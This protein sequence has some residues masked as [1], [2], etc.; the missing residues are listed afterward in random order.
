M[1]KSSNTIDGL[2]EL[3]TQ[4]GTLNKQIEKLVSEKLHLK[5]IELFD[6][7]PNLV[8]FSWTQYANFF[9]DGDPCNFYVHTDSESIDVEF[10]EDEGDSKQLDDRD[11][12]KSYDYTT[13]S[14]KDTGEADIN[15]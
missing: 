13:R 7:Y 10:A 8:S 14:Y 5:F 15:F 1:R 6:E 11:S 4:I 2:T 3:T 9:N 12:G